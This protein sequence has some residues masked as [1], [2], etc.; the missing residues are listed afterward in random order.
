MLLD[1]APLGMSGEE[2]SAR[3]LRT[4]RIAAT[5]MAGWGSRDAGRYLRFVFANEPCR[6]LAGAGERIRQ[7]LR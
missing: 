5:P 4:A 2:A 3:L 7:A 1:C 6:R